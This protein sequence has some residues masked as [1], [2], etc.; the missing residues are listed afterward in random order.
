[1]RDRC[2]LSIKY[3]PAG[4]AR[5]LG[6]FLRY[7]QFRDQ[8]QDLAENRSLAGLTKYIA[9]RDRSAP[10]G[11]LFG[12]RGNCGDLDRRALLT[13][14]SR[15]IQ[16]GPASRHPRAAYRRTRCTGTSPRSI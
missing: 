8:H 12:P 15:S 1:M 3:V 10:G 6:G 16:N 7:V 4:S 13:H 9:H 14:I 2:I 11:R 5:G